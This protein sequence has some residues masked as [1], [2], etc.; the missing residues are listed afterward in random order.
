[1]QEQCEVLFP[2]RLGEAVMQTLQAWEATLR[3]T[4]HIGNVANWTEPQ[5][6]IR[7]LLTDFYEI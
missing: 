1:V 7:T 2:I 5:R 6:R 3:R 4:R